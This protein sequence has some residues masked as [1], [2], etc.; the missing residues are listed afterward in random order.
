MVTQVP[1]QADQVGAAYWVRGRL[2][3]AEIFG[4]APICA[5]R[6]VMSSVQPWCTTAKSCTCRRLLEGLTHSPL[7]RL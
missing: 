5:S 4:S 2:I 7:A 3:G 6:N 1:S